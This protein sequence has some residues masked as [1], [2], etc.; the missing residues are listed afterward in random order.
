MKHPT[1]AEWQG[2]AEQ[3]GWRY[4]PGDWNGDTLEGEIKECPATFSL[5]VTGTSGNNSHYTLLSVPCSPLQTF[6]I[7]IRYHN[8][9]TRFFVN[10]FRGQ[11]IKTGDD[12]FDKIRR[13]MG[14]PAEVLQRFCDDGEL[15]RRLIDIEHF[16]FFG[17]RFDMEKKELQLLAQDYVKNE[18][19]LLEMVEVMKVALLRLA[20][21]KVVSPTVPQQISEER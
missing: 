6:N 8:A 5:Y 10:L 18:Y 20:Y 12:R 15:R 2:F 4:H 16:M 7:D 13:V 9:P 19:G 17:L 3:Y 11:D 14:E 1:K 21:I